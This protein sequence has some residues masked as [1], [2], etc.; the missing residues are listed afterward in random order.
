MRTALLW[1]LTG[2]CAYLLG[3]IPF[4]LLFARLRGVDIRAVGSRNIG[5]TNVFRCVGKSWGILTLL[6]DLG[7]GLCG[8]VAVPWLAAACL[9]QQEPPYLRLLGGGMAVIGHNWPVYLGFKGGKGVATSAGL[10][11]G[12][13]P[14][15]CGLAL[16][17]WLLA[18]LALRYVSLASI[19]AAAALGMG[20]WFAPFRPRQ[21]AQEPLLTPALTALAAL[22]IARH[23]ANIA[24]LL[25]GTESRFTLKRRTAD[26]QE[27]RA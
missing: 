8:T 5:A 27:R 20:V 13:A 12:L 6:L 16:A 24:R 21:A 11:L 9:G 18:L 2:L 25:A 7:K 17:V 22:A 10:L 19:L 15:A 1:T 3:A 26:G 23:R 14:A 4:G